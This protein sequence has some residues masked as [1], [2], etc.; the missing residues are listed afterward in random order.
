MLGTQVII[1]AGCMCLEMRSLLES[2]G[3]KPTRLL[4]GKWRLYF[5]VLLDVHSC[6]L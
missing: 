3:T 6:S 2:P 5:R 4:V 1:L